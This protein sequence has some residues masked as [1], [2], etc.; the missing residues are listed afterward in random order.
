MI[1][2]YF[3]IEYVTKFVND[4]KL[5]FIVYSLVVVLTVVSYCFI[6]KGFIPDE[7]QGVLV[8]QITLPDGASLSRTEEVARRFVEQVKDIVGVDADKLTIFGGMG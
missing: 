5:V 3:Y 2:E 7:D 4:K 6:S 1:G 8:S